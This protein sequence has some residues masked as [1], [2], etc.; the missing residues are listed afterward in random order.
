MLQ[1]EVKKLKITAENINS[2]LTKSNTVIKNRK[3]KREQLEKIITARSI[4]RDKES[5]LEKK[6][7]KGGMFKSSLDGI[8]KTNSTIA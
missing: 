4:R 3:K 2:V 6:S 8:K 1:E 5:N 7:V